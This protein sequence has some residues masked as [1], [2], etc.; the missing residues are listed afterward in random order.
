VLQQT[1]FSVA[2]VTALIDQTR[3]NLGRPVVVGVSG[4]A[5]S[6]KS[7]L[8]RSVVDAD[9]SMVRMRGDDFLDPSRSHRRSGDWDGVE[10]DRLAFEVLAPFRERREGLFRR[11]DWSRRTLGVPEPLPTGHVLLVV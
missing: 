6:G 11:Y 3:Q 9:S 10:R 1:A 7:T 2:D 8:V 4:Y 5:G